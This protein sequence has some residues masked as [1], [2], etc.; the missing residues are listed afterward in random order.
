MEEARQET[1]RRDPRPD[2]RV[3][4][5]KNFIS[6]A[7]TIQNL[8]ENGCGGVGVLWSKKGAM[9][10][11]H[12]HQTDWHYLFVLEGS[13]LYYER[14]VGSTE[15]PTPALVRAGELIYTPPMVEH[16]LV[17]LER[18]T[19]VSMSLLGRDHASHEDDVVRVKLA[20]E[21]GV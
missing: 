14:P 13:L 2:F 7:G 17:F 20:E 11:N 5:P 15:K 19:M 21:L 16:V 10:A 1:D 12:F 8:T 18:T 9:R 4:L 3:K 6:S